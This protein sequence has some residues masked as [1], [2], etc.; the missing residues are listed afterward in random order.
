MT[1]KKLHILF[2]NSWYP[3]KVFP[4]NGDFIQRHAEAVATKHQI[5]AIH[6]ITD[7]SATKNIT[8]ENNINGVRTL[9]TYIK[10][11]SST[12]VKQIHFFRAY[13]DLIHLSGSFD[14]VHLN[15]LFPVGI[16]AIWLKIFHSIPF[17]ISEHFTGYLQPLSNKLSKTEIYFAK[18]ITKHACFVCP[19]SQN[20]AKSMQNLG[21]EGKYH[22]VANTIDSD[23]FEPKSIKK[24]TLTLIHI[25]NLKNDHKN[26]VGILNVIAKLQH[27]ITHFIFYL[28]G[29]NPFQYQVLID[30]LD[31]NPD[32][33]R[34]I[35]QIPHQKVPFYLQKSDILIL[36]SNYENLPCVILEAFACGTKVISSD[37]GGID[38]FF[39]KNFGELIPSKDENQLLKSILKIQSSQASV[40][41]TEMHKYATNNFS[42]EIICNNFSELYSKSLLNKNS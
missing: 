9:I 10:P 12:I 40:T 24:K 11:K 32:R 17:I 41:K 1:K 35:D 39:P 31:I 19:V 33:I 22:P 2:L 38:E 14:I 37:V 34:L 36:F 29:D 18:R 28:I 20:L 42:T 13:K 23:I 27:H 26:I 21:F 6:V 7:E 8:T 25:S 15:R 5:T 16:I 30:S 3:S 4:N